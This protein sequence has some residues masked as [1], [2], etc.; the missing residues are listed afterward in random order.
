MSIVLITV[1]Y[2]DSNPTKDLINSILNCKMNKNIKIIIVDNESSNSSLSAL[3]LITKKSNLDIEI[4]SSNINSYYWGGIQ[5]GLQKIYNNNKKYDWIIACNNDVQF[6]DISLFEKLN[7]LKEDYYNI[8]APRIIS[9]LT[10]KDLNPFMLKPISFLYNIYYSLYYLNFFTSIIFHKIG[11][12]IKLIKIESKVNDSSNYQI[13]AGHGSC[14]IFSKEFFS[15]GGYLDNGFTMYGEE[16]STAEIANKIKSFIYY[17]PSLSLIHNE[18]QSTSK[19]SLKS[20]F[21]HSK[22]TY[23]YLKKKYRS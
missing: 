23:Y 8:I 2:K 10:N 18:H 13:Y 11:R 16:V 22:K 9:S 7:D 3:K 15:N 6:N 12:L 19:S 14:I 17:V 21:L 20:N 5:L 4:I 1:N